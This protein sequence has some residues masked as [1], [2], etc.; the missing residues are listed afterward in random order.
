MKTLIAISLSLSLLLPAIT[1]AQSNGSGQKIV[2]MDS[3]LATGDF[4][5]NRVVDQWCWSRPSVLFNNEASNSNPEARHYNIFSMCQNQAQSDFSTSTAAQIPRTAFHNIA[6]YYTNHVF[7]TN[8]G[9][10]VLGKAAV[11]ASGAR[12]IV[13]N[14]TYYD[15][16]RRSLDVNGERK[17][18]GFHGPNGTPMNIAG[19]QQPS[20]SIGCYSPHDA[21]RQ[22]E[23]MA[24]VLVTSNVAAVNYSADAVANCNLNNSTFRTLKDRNIAFIASAGNGGA[25]SF[26][27]Y[28]ACNS[29]VISVGA[30]TA[31]LNS[32]H[33]VTSLRGV[34]LDFLA[35]GTAPDLSLIHI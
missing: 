6:P 20:S 30:V 18:C 8:H 19:V 27:G 13:I 22:S 31:N 23:V 10:T 1:V 34:K 16:N 3:G 29:N 28:P 7:G 12:F 2:I 14:N 11:T 9:S 17:Q 15:S 25:S 26:I 5:R 4:F 33:P 24:K 35:T 32:V 21:E